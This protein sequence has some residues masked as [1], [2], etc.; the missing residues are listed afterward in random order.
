MDDDI[1]QPETDEAAAANS[2]AVDEAP[3]EDAPTVA[4]VTAPTAESKPAD[5]RAVVEQIRDARDRITAE[6][7]KAIIGQEEVVEQIIIAMF[8]R[9]HCLM[10]GV[11]GL[12]KTLLVKS[13]A[14]IFSLSFKRVQFTP[15]L[16]PADIYGTE[17]VEEDAVTGKRLFSFVKGPVFANIVLADEINRTPP[18]TQAA[19]LEAMEERQVTAAGQTHP[20]DKPF[21]VLATQ[22]PIELEGTYPLPEAQLDR[23]L[24]NVVLDYLPIELEEQMVLRTTNPSKPELQE[25]FTGPEIEKIQ[26]LVREVPVSSNVVRYAVRLVSATRKTDAAPEY[27]REMVKWGAGSRASQA[28]I[29]AGKARALLH[30]RYNVAIEDVKA[31]AVPVLRHRVVTN[32][33]A[34]AEGVTTDDII[35]RLLNDIPE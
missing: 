17:V 13:I 24:F 15:D 12:G 3:A 28:L 8:S 31:L 18:K 7:S 23:F 22:N 21:F 33:H 4:A 1:Q 20:L 32:F 27:V 34:D 25:I 19:L 10:T 11:P 26:Q 29:L 9:G 16:M 14:E 2:E 35:Q 30:G 5:G 6:L